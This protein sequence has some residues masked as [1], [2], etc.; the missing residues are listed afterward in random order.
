MVSVGRV[1]AVVVAGYRQHRIFRVAARSGSL[2]V[3]SRVGAAASRTANDLLYLEI[4][5]ARNGSTSRFVGWR[6][7]MCDPTTRATLC[8][9]SAKSPKP[10]LAAGCRCPHPT[11]PVRVAS[12]QRH[13]PSGR[14]RPSCRSPPSW[15]VRCSWPRRRSCASACSRIRPAVVRFH[16]VVGV[17]LDDVPCANGD[18]RPT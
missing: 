1:A 13:R 8:R 2:D 3:W 10:L 14:G 15:T 12:S 17:L 11:L 16:S 18:D 4:R 9:A 7:E 5:A 6:D